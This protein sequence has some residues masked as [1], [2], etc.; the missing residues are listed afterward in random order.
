MSEQ[1]PR[2]CRFVEPQGLH[3]AL[4]QDSPLFLKPRAV[5]GTLTPSGPDSFPPDF[6]PFWK[7]LHPARGT[8]GSCSHKHPGFSPLRLSKSGIAKSSFLLPQQSLVCRSKLLSSLLREA[9]FPV[10]LP[11]TP[12]CHFYSLWPALLS[13]QEACS[14]FTIISLACPLPPQAPSP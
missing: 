12:A 11:R 5:A 4:I 2:G 9:C 14:F 6:A 8:S 3:L 10:S 7:T 1:L 13:P